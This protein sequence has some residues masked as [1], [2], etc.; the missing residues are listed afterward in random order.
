MKELEVGGASRREGRGI[1]QGSNED[2]RSD[3]ASFAEY[4]Y[5]WAVGII[6]EH[7]ALSCSSS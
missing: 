3:A 1:L 4:N 5:S 7:R 2:P 6:K